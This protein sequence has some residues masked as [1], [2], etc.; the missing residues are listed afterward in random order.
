MAGTGLTHDNKA[1]N[2]SCA[3]SFSWAPG[4]RGLRQLTRTKE[5]QDDLW[6]TRVF[7]DL[8][9]SSFVKRREFLTG[10]SATQVAAAPLPLRSR[11]SNGCRSVPKGQ[12]PREWIIR[13]LF[14][15]S[16]LSGF[17]QLSPS[18]PQSRPSSSHLCF[19]WSP[20]LYS[21]LTSAPPVH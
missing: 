16:F 20:C 15:I 13:P 19:F 8:P 11:W 3:I 6:S 10:V 2:P 9:V 21:F 17:S 12:S 1:I 14:S 7:G 4:E 5:P 18:L